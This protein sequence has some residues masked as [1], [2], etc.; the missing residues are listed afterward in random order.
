MSLI[1]KKRLILVPFLTMLN[2]FYLTKRPS[3]LVYNIEVYNLH[4]NFVP[5]FI[6]EESL[7]KLFLFMT[8]IFFKNLPLLVIVFVTVTFERI[9]WKK[10]EKLLLGWTIFLQNVIVFMTKL[11]QP[12]PVLYKLLWLWWSIFKCHSGL[13]RPDVSFLPHIL[14]EL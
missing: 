9:F 14:D 1:C 4:K 13:C 12:K 10:S 3:L 2:Y 6:F 8:E 5:K 7:K 11:H